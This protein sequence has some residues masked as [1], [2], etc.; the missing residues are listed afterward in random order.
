[1]PTPLSMTASSK[2]LSQRRPSITIRPS[3]RPAKPCSVAFC[4]RLVTIWPSGP[5]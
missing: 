5:G 2:P 4:S 1:M 3:E